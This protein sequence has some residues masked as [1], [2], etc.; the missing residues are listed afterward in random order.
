MVS[1]WRIS[2]EKV[3]GVVEL[4]K[5]WLVPNWLIR[6][7]Q[8]RGLLFERIRYLDKD[9][10]IWN[11]RPFVFWSLARTFAIVCEEISSRL[12]SQISSLAFLFRQLWDKISPGL[13]RITRERWPRNFSSEIFQLIPSEFLPLDEERESWKSLKS[14]SKVHFGS[15]APCLKHFV[16]RVRDK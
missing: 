10:F 13:T 6:K 16:Y 12:S 2:L 4:F 7:M 9:H 1:Y 11:F 8:S 3:E 14:I 5:I 15:I